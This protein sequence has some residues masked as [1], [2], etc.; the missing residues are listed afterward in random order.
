LT[1][2]LPEFIS[3]VSRSPVESLSSYA[4]RQRVKII[5]EEEVDELGVPLRFPSRI[6]GEIEVG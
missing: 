2:E 1:A 4:H 6:F 3:P 5:E